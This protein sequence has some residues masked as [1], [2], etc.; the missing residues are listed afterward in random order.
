ME[1][2]L[3]E[4]FQLLFKKTRDRWKE[5]NGSN[6]RNIKLKFNSFSAAFDDFVFFANKI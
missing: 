2:A 3:T 5:E 6:W 1:K 4:T